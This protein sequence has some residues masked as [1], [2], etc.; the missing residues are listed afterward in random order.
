MRSAWEL[1][2]A[3]SGQFLVAGCFDRTLRIWD[4]S[5]NRAL[6]AH[7]QDERV[8][9]I[10]I[11]DTMIATGNLAGI[12]TWYNLPSGTYASSQFRSS[13]RVESL[14]LSDMTTVTRHDNGQAVLWR[15]T[16]RRTAGTPKAK[17]NHRDL[18]NST[19]TQRK[20]PATSARG[21]T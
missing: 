19:T 10:A 8:V 14:A 13:S 12:V 18:T 3:R 16:L 7:R 11:T 15:S 6:A 2:S 17:Q 21:S 9:H 1:V 20:P 4:V 5:S